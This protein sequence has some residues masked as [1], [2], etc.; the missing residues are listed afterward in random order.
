MCADTKFFKVRAATAHL[1]Y[2]GTA[3]SSAT[4]DRRRKKKSLEKQ[5]IA[6]ADKASSD[7]KG[8]DQ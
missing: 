6:V 8:R 7:S 5:Y 4:G 3:Q 1:S 2:S